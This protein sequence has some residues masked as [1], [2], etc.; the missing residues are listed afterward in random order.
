MENILIGSDQ[1]DSEGKFELSFEDKSELVPKPVNKVII[2]TVYFD[3]TDQA[4]ETQSFSESVSFSGQSM[5]LIIN[6]E[7]YYDVKDTQKIS[8]SAFNPDMDTICC[9]M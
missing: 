7:N 2:Y 3:V 9:R 5:Y 4:G 6:A 8:I 1:A